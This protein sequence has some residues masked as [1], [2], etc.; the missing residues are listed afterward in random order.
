[1]TPNKH[2]MI[3]FEINSLTP[4]DLTSFKR[5]AAKEMLPLAT[6][7]KRVLRRSASKVKA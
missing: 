4:D 1:M 5:A 6:W 7:A 2:P 3:R